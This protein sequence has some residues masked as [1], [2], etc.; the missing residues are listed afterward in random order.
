MPPTSDAPPQVPSCRR[1]G[2]ERFRRGVKRSHHAA[3]TDRNTPGS[4]LIVNCHIVHLRLFARFI[5]R[6][7]GEPQLSAWAREEMARDLP[8][9][10]FVVGEDTDMTDWNQRFARAEATGQ[11]AAYMRIAIGES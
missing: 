4:T 8:S 9:A 5:L 1:S 3:I 2:E 7:I 11:R 10:G 6:V